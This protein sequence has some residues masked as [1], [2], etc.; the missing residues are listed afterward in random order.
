MS[1]MVRSEKGK[2]PGPSSNPFISQNASHRFLVIHNTHVIS[3]RIVV[4]ADFEHLNLAS[5]LNTS[6][7]EYLVTIKKL[8]YP[9]L[10]RYFYA[11]LTF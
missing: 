7:P 6:S 8:V 11:N 3:G 1:K 5:V 10:M 2:Q 9:E 4:L